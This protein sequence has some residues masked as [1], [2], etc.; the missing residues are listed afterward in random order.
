MRREEFYK[1]LKEH[2]L[3][4]DQFNDLRIKWE[5]L[6]GFDKLILLSNSYSEEGVNNEENL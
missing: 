6:S 1:L 5:S 3:T 4:V 2:N